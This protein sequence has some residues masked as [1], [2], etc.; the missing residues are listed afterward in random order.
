MPG[1]DIIAHLES[2]LDKM[3]D[4]IEMFDISEK[5]FEKR[6]P[7]PPLKTRNKQNR[8]EVIE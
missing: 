4:G 3:K 6:Y 7:S 2:V 8:K 5:E 1:E